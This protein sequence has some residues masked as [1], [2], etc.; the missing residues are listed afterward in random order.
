MPKI[1]AKKIP[2]KRKPSKKDE[3]SDFDK[4]TFKV[5]LSDMNTK[6]LVV[7]KEFRDLKKEFN[8]IKEM[9]KEQAIH[10]GNYNSSLA[11]LEREAKKANND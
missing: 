9:V 10:N 11:K 3:F 8:E 2:T 6:L 7:Y 1:P 5:K 4:K